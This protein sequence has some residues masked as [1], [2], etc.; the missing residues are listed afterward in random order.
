M[1]C[2]R[3]HK[4]RK[5]PEKLKVFVSEQFIKLGNSIRIDELV[6]TCEFACVRTFSFML[7]KI[8]VAYNGNESNP[9]FY[10]GDF[11]YHSCA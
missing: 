1:D 6:V 4:H 9:F 10:I 5:Y 8:R 3:C 7:L 11:S 2:I